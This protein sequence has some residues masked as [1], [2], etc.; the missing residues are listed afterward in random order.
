MLLC[1]HNL[2]SYRTEDEKATKE[3]IKKVDKNMTQVGDDP[4]EKIKD[5]KQDWNKK[6]R[7]NKMRKDDN[8][9]PTKEEI[10]QFKKEMINK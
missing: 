4:K 7:K 5:M 8:D 6:G 10:R 2:Y 1:T 3:F 9:E